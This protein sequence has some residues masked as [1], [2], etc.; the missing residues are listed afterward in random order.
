M[1]DS[2]EASK[3]ALDK[4]ASRDKSAYVARAVF[5][6]AAHTPGGSVEYNRSGRGQAP[7]VDF[8]LDFDDQRIDIRGSLGAEVRNIFDDEKRRA[9]SFKAVVLP[10]SYE[11][12]PKARHTFTRAVEHGALHSVPSRVMRPRA[13]ANI[14]SVNKNDLPLFG[15]PT[16]TASPRAESSPS[17]AHG[18]SASAMTSSIA[19]AE[20]LV[21]GRANPSSGRVAILAPTRLGS[22][23][24]LQIARLM[25]TSHAEGT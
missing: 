8:T 16:I 3:G 4:A 11:A 23:P 19:V 7:F 13:T 2:N 21:F 9:L 24:M 14:A 6:A 25:T 15:G 10:H 12:A 22:V 18:G 20:N 5:V 1:N 17:I